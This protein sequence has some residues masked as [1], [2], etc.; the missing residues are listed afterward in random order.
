MEFLSGIPAGGALFNTAAIVAGGIVGL[1]AGRFIPEK[2]GKLVFQCLGL[3]CLYL[4]FS[5]AREF[6]IFFY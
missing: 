3:F 1:L 4:G 2:A 6:Y 5:M